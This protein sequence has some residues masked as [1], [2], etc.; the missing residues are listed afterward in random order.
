VIPPRLLASLVICSLTL[1]IAISVL[2]GVGRLLA[3][4]GDTGGGAVV[5]RVAL[6]A[7]IL[8][9]VLLICLVLVLGIL[10]HGQHREPPEE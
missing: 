4:M 9:I 10:A 1:P 3:A 2:A 8:W 6:S 7:G 5:D